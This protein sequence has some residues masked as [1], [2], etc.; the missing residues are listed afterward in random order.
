MNNKQQVKGM[1]NNLSGALSGTQPIIDQPMGRYPG[2]RIDNRWIVS[3]RGPG[4]AVDP[5]RPN[6]FFTEKEYIAAGR[7]E[8]TAVILLTNRECPYKCLMCDLWKNTTGSRVPSGAIPSQIEYALSS[9]PPARHIKLFNSGSFFDPEAIPPEDYEKI[10]KLLEPFDTVMVE[11]HPRFVGERVSAFRK[12]IRGDLQV[13][14]GLETVHPEILPLLN[15]KM[16]LSLFDKAVHALAAHGIGVRAF[17]LLRPPFL[18]EEEGI[19][20]AERSVDH[21][22]QTG[23]H[24]C[25]IIPVRGGNGAL[26]TLAGSGF[27]HPPEITSLEKVLEYGISLQKGHVFA[28]L[29][30]IGQFSSC[31]ECLEARKKRL[32][33]MNLYQKIFPETECSCS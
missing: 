31:E 11:S 16:T 6:A 22:F 18:T 2:F 27:F 19:Y 33:L 10:A 12:M 28:D 7:I 9:L 25:T 3:Q 14:M 17:I 8:E 13:A 29:W 32:E 20:W 24:S 23:V 1:E 15:K 30:D 26:D 4:N 5:Y 21:A